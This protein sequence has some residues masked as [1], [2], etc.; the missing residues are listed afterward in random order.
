[1]YAHQSAFEIW[2]YTLLFA[3]DM[4]GHRTKT[5]SSNV[6]SLTVVIGVSLSELFMCFAPISD[7]N[8]RLA[9]SIVLSI[10]IGVLIP[11]KFRTTDLEVKRRTI[12]NFA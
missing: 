1:M 3:I 8:L 4:I 11:L 7:L 6:F 12:R 10:I 5:I 2:N 9:I